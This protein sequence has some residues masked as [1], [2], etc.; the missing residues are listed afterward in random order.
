MDTLLAFIIGIA[1]GIAFY[2]FDFRNGK[3][4]YRKWH[5]LTHKDPLPEGT[6]MGFVY[7]QPFSGKLYT[8]VFLAVVITLI[9]IFFG[10]ANF[11]IELLYGAFILV[12]LM[13]A[14]YV[15]PLIFRHSG[16]NMERIKKVVDKVDKLEDK[17]RD[18]FDGDDKEPEKVV[19][20]KKEET[21]PEEK[22][23]P[24]QEDKKDDDW[25]K[26]IKDFLND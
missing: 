1:G 19:E 25:R 21:K 24:K 3:S 10:S 6:E 11:L 2:F 18:T 15:S 17:I 26:G 16:K 8:A 23:E 13:I 5:A 9:V 7:R 4:R 14:F 12:G 22:E 20:E